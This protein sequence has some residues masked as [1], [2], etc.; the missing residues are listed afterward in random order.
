MKT[1]DWHN[2]YLLQARWTKNLRRFIFDMLN[3]TPGQTVLD[4][5][6]A[7]ARFM[8]TTKP[9]SEAYRNRS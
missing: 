5:G 9:R 1:P 8:K 4:V 6:A 2:R 3:A 7:P